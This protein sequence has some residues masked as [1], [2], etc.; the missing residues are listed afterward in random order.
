MRVARKPG[1]IIQHI[2]LIAQNRIQPVAL[3]SWGIEIRNIAQAV[4]RERHDHK[5]HHAH[6]DRRQRSRPEPRF[7]AEK[8]LLFRLT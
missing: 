1:M 6:A 7:H 8:M 5:E 4:N 2:F 3:I